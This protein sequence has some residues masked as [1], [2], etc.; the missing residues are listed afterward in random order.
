MTTNIDAQ[1][2]FDDRAADLACAFFE[3]YLVHV[4]G[5]WAGQAFKLEPWQRDGI[6][7]PLFGWKRR[8]A[9]KPEEC[10]RRYRTAYI[11]VPRKCGKSTLAAGI[12][13]YLL[14]ADHE[15]GAEVYS[16]A[17]DRE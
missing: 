6:I 13:L 7:R 1:F 15:H 5:E 8:D 14:F 3:K 12:A 17:A 4:K 10:S 16:A 2:W 9:D 11:F